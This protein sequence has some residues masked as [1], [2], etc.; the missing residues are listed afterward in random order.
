MTEA[1]IL[2]LAIK[3]AGT[4][5]PLIMDAIRNGDVH[6]LEALQQ[7]IQSPEML[8]ASDAALA[9]AERLRAASALAPDVTYVPETASPDDVVTAVK[10]L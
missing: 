2:S 7:H 10:P 5:I 3:A 4:L 8:A 1:D 6:A 9:Q